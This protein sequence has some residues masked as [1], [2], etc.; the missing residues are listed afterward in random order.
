MI[1]EHV[2]QY[3]QMNIYDISTV[4]NMYLYIYI[5]ILQFWNISTPTILCDEQLWYSKVLQNNVIRFE[6]KQQYN[7]KI[8]LYNTIQHNMILYDIIWYL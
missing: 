4:Y 3:T 2:G 8:K 6:L 7:N 5:C 1:W